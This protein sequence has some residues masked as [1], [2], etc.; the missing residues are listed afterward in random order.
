MPDSERQELIAALKKKW[1]AVHKE[2]QRETHYVKLDTLGKKNRME[3]YM[4]EMD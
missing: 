1:E 3:G 2:Y 4:R